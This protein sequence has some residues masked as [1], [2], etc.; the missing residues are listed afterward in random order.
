M[1]DFSI[2]PL[3][4]IIYIYIYLYLSIY[5]YLYL[6]I[7]RVWWVNCRH[8]ELS[9]PT[10][11]F[12]L[13]FVNCIIYKSQLRTDCEESSSMKQFNLETGQRIKK[14]WMSPMVISK[15]GSL[16]LIILIRKNLPNFSLRSRLWL[17]TI[18]AS[19]SG[20]RQGHGSVCFFF[21]SGS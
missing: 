10:I 4:F 19:P 3:I 7:H 13:S 18:P 6:Y 9:I 16:I 1:F 11:L 21:L 5:I 20:R 14:N 2:S 17:T 12:I 8:F 15:V